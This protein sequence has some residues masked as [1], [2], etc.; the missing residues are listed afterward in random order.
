LRRRPETTRLLDGQGSPTV[1]LVS[2]FNDVPQQIRNQIIDPLA[3]DAT[4][5]TY[6]RAGIGE[7]EIGNPPHTP[8]NRPSISAVSWKN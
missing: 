1:V 3:A 7:S 5:V 2:G 6:D 8:G 4:I